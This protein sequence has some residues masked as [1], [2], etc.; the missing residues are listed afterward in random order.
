MVDMRDPSE[1]SSPPPGGK[2][3][4]VRRAITDAFCAEWQ[5]RDLSVLDIMNITYDNKSLRRNEDI[6]WGKLVIRHLAS[7]QVTLGRIDNRK[8]RH[9]AI[10]VFQIFE[11]P[12]ES[13]QRAEGIADDA[14]QVFNAIQPVSSEY[15]AEARIEPITFQVPRIVEVGVERELPSIYQLHVEARFAYY[16]RH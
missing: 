2:S 16:E 13:I 10:A 8:F 9:D 4:I 11:H 6:P 7:E 5:R 15:F 1:P 12:D 14:C 3:A